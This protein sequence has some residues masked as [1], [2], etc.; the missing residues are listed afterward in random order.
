MNVLQL[1]SLWNDELKAGNEKSECAINGE[2][3]SE[4][5]PSGETNHTSDEHEVPKDIS[6]RRVRYTMLFLMNDRFSC[7]LFLHMLNELVLVYF[8]LRVL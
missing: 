2:P 4:C 1:M 8:T 7:C 5:G 3:E 6:S